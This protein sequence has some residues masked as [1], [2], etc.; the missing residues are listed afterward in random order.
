MVRPKVRGA[1]EDMETR[2]RVAPHSLAL[3]L[4]Q[5]CAPAEERRAGYEVFASFKAVN[6][7]HFWDKAL[8]RA[9]AELF[10][11]GW[12]DEQ[13]LL[14]QGAEIHLQVLRN[15]WTRRT[16]QPPHGFGIK[17][18]GR[19]VEASQSG[20]KYKALNFTLYP[21]SFGRVSFLLIENGRTKN[22]HVTLDVDST[23]LFYTGHAVLTMMHL[24]A[25]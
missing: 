12:I 5:L 15:A 8:T 18:I 13:V 7:Q 1:H 9:L 20:G 3:A 2:L 23:S 14:V 10:F 22:R 21:L 11:L 6:M 25:G 19:N 17:S 4:A 16:L 24:R